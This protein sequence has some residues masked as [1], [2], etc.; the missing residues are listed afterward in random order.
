MQAKIKRIMNM[1][2]Y[3]ESWDIMLIKDNGT[4]LFP[5]NTLEILSKSTAQRLKKKYT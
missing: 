3:H 2:F 5:D 4:H 1:L